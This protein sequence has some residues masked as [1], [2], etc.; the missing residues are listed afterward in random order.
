MH[1]WKPRFNVAPSQHMPIKTAEGVRLATWGLIPKWSP[2]FELPK[3]ST[4]NARAE[5]IFES[6]LYSRPIKTQR[7]LIPA[8]SFFEWK[9]DGEK[10]QPMLIHLKSRPLFYF[11]G[12]FETWHDEE[13]SYSILTTE[14]NSFMENIHNRQPLILDKDEEKK[15]LDPD[16][17]EPEQIEKL[18]KP[19]SA[20]DFDAYPVSTL[21][22]R[23]SNDTE[24]VTE[25]IQ[26]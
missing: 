26:I 16:L 18:L 12:I 9:K 8:N 2:K 24:V 25:K 23:P 5:T 14:P 20:E 13:V 10:K 3:F 1:G 11:G 19:T 15:W 21:V 6:K 17:V 4:I 22:N 7:A